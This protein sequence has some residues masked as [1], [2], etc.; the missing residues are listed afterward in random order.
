MERKLQ[1]LYRSSH[2][3]GANAAYIE[4]WYESWLQDPSSVPEHW[5][6]EFAA[7][8]DGEADGEQGQLVIRERFR[9]LGQLPAS[10]MQ[11]SRIADHKEAAVLKLI[12]AYRI[13]GHEMARLDPLGRP[14]RD[15]VPDLTLA[16]NDLDETDL[17]LEFDTG[18][19]VAPKRMKL[20]AIIELCERVYCGSIGVE[21]MHIV[22]T[23]KRY[24]LQ[25]RLEGCSGY[26]QVDDEERVRILEMLTAAEG[27]ERYLH[28]RYVGQKRFSLEGGDSLIPL[29]HETMLHA[30]RQGVEEIVF[31]M[32]HRGRLN[33][34]VNI[35]GKSPAML[36]DEFEGK[37]KDH[38]PLRSGDVKYHLGFASDIQTPGGK[39]HMALAFNPSHLEIVDPV[40]VGSAKARQIRRKDES[41]DQVMPILIHGDAAFAGQGVVMELFQ[42]S[43]ARG[44]AVGGTLHI[45][46]NNQVGFTTSDPRDARSTPYCTAVAK[47]VNA[48]IFHVNADDPEAVHHVMKIACDFRT[49]FKRD[50]VIDLFC[51]RRHGHNEAD[52]P[53][54][55]QPLMYQTIRAMDTTRQKYADQLVQAGIIDSSAADAMM[56]RYR[57]HLDRGDQVANVTT[58][59]R[60]NEYA[61][62]WHD[63]TNKELPAIVETAVPAERIRELS[64]RLT[65]LPDGFELHS[66]VKRVIEDRRKMAAGE[67]PMDWGFAET[68]A[69]ATLIDE[70]TG[71]RLVGQDSGRGTFFHRHAVLHNQK[72]GATLL[73]LGRLKDDIHVSVIDSLLSEEAVL[74]FEYGYATAAP[75]TL[76]IWEAQFGDFVN[77]AQVVI[78]QF[79]A[80][81]EAKWGRLCGLTLFLPHGYEGQG[82]EHSSARLERFM[83]L[84]ANYNIQV[85]IPSTP[86]QMFH[87][88]RRQVLQPTRKPLIVMTPKSLLR[89]KASTS[90]MK[91]LAEG[92]FQRVIGDRGPGDTEEIERVILCSGKVYY[93][94]VQIRDEEEIRKVAVLRLEQLY[95]FPEE[96]VAEFIAEFPNASEVIWCQEEPKNQGAWYQIRHHLQACVRDDQS[97]TYA[98]R[99]QSPSPAVGYYTIHIEQQRALVERALTG[100]V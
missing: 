77:G 93:D 78:D 29:L 76:V 83:Q 98:G 97:L 38:D 85:C 51:Y 80:S 13:R 63:F 70:G 58:Q 1:A 90:E 33:V 44:F 45:V 17:D 4:D 39:V 96:Q 86:A 24:W 12:N 41:Y 36:F 64:E 53:A 14:H 3:F 19:L 72:D 52:E 18:T 62:N 55:T 8:A 75:E 26:H 10:A 61:A 5:A 56:Q 47:M 43:E 94:L 89:S 27:L 35:L 32:A 40:V 11:D 42:M 73:P 67:I 37:L 22:D 30:G 81:G 65:T 34:L 74:G 20:S 59:P 99:A 49:K 82:P 50:V 2:L 16:F 9:Q 15:P 68:M 21:Y 66:R 100:P 7:V 31:G 25:E 79:L 23:V 95:P 28:T 57:D 91:V 6:R 48:P 92:H 71:L 87:L 69:Y 46:V 84:S 60:T 88:L 54:A